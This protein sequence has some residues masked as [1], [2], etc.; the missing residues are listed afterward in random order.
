[1]A[2]LYLNGLL[3]GIHFFS[4]DLNNLSSVFENEFECVCEEKEGKDRQGD[5]H[6]CIVKAVVHPLASPEGV[7]ISS[8]M[9]FFVDSENDNRRKNKRNKTFENDF[10]NRKYHY[11]NH[12]NSKSCLFQPNKIKT[13]VRNKNMVKNPVFSRK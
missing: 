10:K 7:V 6:H 1:M 9:K 8:D 11:K 12:K 3:G 13:L 4:Q 2:S 5:E